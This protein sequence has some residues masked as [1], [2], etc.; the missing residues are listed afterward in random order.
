MLYY[1]PAFDAYSN[2]LIELRVPAAKRIPVSELDAV[3][4][5]CNAVNIGQG[6]IV[7]QVSEPLKQQLAAIGFEV[8]ETPLSEFLKAGGGGKMS[9]P[10]GHRANSRRSPDRGCRRSQ[11]DSDGRASV[12][13]RVD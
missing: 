12:G 6:I 5:A 9:D 13:F 10:A 7:N 8:L 2:H 3:N 1:P 11:N 4:F